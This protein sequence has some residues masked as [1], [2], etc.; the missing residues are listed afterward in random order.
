MPECTI[1]V[2]SVD[3]D[4]CMISEFNVVWCIIR[5]REVQIFGSCL[6]IVLFSRMC[7]K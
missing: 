2:E 7:W 1:R 6:V 4:F 5:L 3:V